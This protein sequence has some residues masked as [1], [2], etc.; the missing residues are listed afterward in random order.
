[1]AI[2]SLPKDPMMLLSFVNT[3][4][5]DDGISLDD[6]ASQFQVERSY[7]EEKL[8]KIGY[9]YNNDLRKFI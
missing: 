6:F 9:T 8:D 1:M 7:I 4:L 5:R 2:E 3:R